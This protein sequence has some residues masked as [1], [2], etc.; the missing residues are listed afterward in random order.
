M[1]HKIFQ[2]QVMPLYVLLLN[3]C[4]DSHPDK[5]SIFHLVL[6]TSK[7][8]HCLQANAYCMYGVLSQYDST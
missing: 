8:L 7:A 1:S 5:L 4:P 2:C 3:A 6:T